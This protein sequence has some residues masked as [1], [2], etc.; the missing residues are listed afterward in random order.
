MHRYLSASDSDVT[1]HGNPQTFRVPVDSPTSTALLR[2]WA[3]V[4]LASRS[5]KDALDAAV[6]VS[7]VFCPGIP[8]EPDALGLEF[9]TPRFATY[10][11][12]CERLEVIERIMDASECYHRMV[13]ELSVEA[14]THSE[15]ATWI[16]GKESRISWG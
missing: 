16:R 1:R 14:D 2:E 15:Q 3:K 11:V 5:W 7:F 13:S 9:I 6:S 4:T 12:L 8:G 10:Q